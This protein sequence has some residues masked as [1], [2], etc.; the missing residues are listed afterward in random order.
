M[1]NVP[2]KRQLDPFKMTEFLGLWLESTGDTQIPWGASGDMTNF[3]VT[4][5]KKLKK[6]DGYVKLFDKINGVTFREIWHGRVLGTLKTIFVAGGKAYDLNLLTGVYTEI[7]TL[8]DG[9]TTIFGFDDKAYFINGSEYKVWDGTTF[10]N[11]TPYTPVTFVG[12]TPNRSTSTPLEP[13]NLLSGSKTEKYIADGTSTQYFVAEQNITSFGTVLVNGVSTSITADLTLGK[14]TFAT[15]PVNGALVEITYTKGTGSP[16][17]VYE[18]KYATIYGANNDTRV[19]LYGRT[20]VNRNKITYSGL[21]NGVPTATY[22]PANSFMKI[23]SDNTS[24]KD[25]VV[26]NTRFIVYK[27]ERA[28]VGY[29][30]VDETTGEAQ[31]PVDA[32]DYM[33]TAPFAQV[34]VCN[35]TPISIGNSLRRMVSTVIRDEKSAPKISE[36]IQSDLDSVDLSNA[37]TCDYEF[38]QWY[39]ISVGQDVWI[40]DYEIDIYSRLQLAHTPVKWIEIDRKLYFATSDGTIMRFDDSVR[41]FDGT[42]IDAHWEMNFSSF[43]QSWIQKRIKEAWISLFPE[44]KSYLRVGLELSSNSPEATKEI[45]YYNIDF[46]DTDFSKWSFTTSYNPQPFR[47]R[48][49][50]KKFAYLKLVVDSDKIDRDVTILEFILPI[51]FGGKIK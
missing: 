50:G 2:V 33:I 30:S 17:E 41:T 20:G 49:K 8:T 48:I 26:N 39:I 44:N 38:K 15:A 40:Y 5:L 45:E 31:F 35:N 27:D 12:Q 21:A 1:A 18:N 43:G 29:N 11:V 46:T 47:I 24:V 7:G 4:K 42:K 9:I 34:R 28:Y 13:I 23:G 37:I 6:T 32:L 22:F 25:M 10:G 19:F 36:R 16:N 51:S 14:A 3:I